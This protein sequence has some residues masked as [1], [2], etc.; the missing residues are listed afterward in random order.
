[1]TD[2]AEKAA[3][4]QF[5]VVAECKPAGLFL[6]P[7]QS[8]ELVKWIRAATAARIKV[9]LSGEGERRDLLTGTDAGDNWLTPTISP[10]KYAI[11]T[12]LAA[13]V[14]RRIDVRP[15][16]R[17]LLALADGKPSPRFIR[18]N[19]VAD[20][21]AVS[22]ATTGDWTTAVTRQRLLDAGGLDLSLGIDRAGD[23]A[24]T[25]APTRLADVWFELSP[26]VPR[27]VAVRWATAP[28]WP[29]PT[30]RLTTKSWPKNGAVGTPAK[31]SAWWSESPFPAAATWTPEPGQTLVGHPSATVNGT[32]IESVTLEVHE[33]A[34]TPG[35][36]AKR[37][38]LVVRLAFAP[39]ETLIARPLEAIPTGGESRVYQ[40]AGK[41][42]CLFWWSDGSRAKAVTGIELVKMS[43]AKKLAIS[44]ALP[45]LPPAAPAA[46]QP[47]PAPR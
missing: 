12:V 29:A 11:R 39:T 37:E 42:T 34:V 35:T 19:A 31:V 5:R 22:R 41:S 3:Q 13:P 17:L 7:D 25:L 40:T 26:A 9:G 32:T 4:D 27:P 47:T 21:P 8:A 6:T 44:V 1:V 18:P 28:G 30:W 33:V 14:E 24:D 10:G 45:P 16:E 23:S 36:L 20:L 38:C 15:G 46:P 43:A 2:A